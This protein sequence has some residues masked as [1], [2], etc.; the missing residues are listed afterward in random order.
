MLLGQLVQVEQALADALLQVQGFR[1]VLETTFP[2][3]G[4]GLSHVQEGEATPTP[5]LQQ[6]QALGHLAMLLGEEQE[7]VGEALQ[8]GAGSR[9]WPGTGR[10]HGAPGRCGC[11]THGGSAGA[12][13]RQLYRR[14]GG[15]WQD[16]LEGVSDE[17]G[18]ARAAAGAEMLAASSEPSHGDI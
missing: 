9:P 15:R 12:R 3:L 7:D 11:C 14:H 18:A 16:H 10:K 17:G 4:L 8:G 13:A 1:H 5:V 2:I 6:H